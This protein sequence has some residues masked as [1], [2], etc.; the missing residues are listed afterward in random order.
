MQNIVKQLPAYISEKP[1]GLLSPVKSA[2]YED[3]RTKNIWNF[4]Y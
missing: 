3:L 2:S 1:S 4:R